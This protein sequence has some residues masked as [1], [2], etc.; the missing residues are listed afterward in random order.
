MVW[1]LIQGHQMPSLLLEFGEMV[2]VLS[3]SKLDIDLFFG[4][5]SSETIFQLVRWGSVQ[6]NLAV[7]QVK[8]PK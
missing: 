8:V 4:F 6:G 5:T 3:Q 7:S 1:P 2:L